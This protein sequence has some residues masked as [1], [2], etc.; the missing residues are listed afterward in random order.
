[1][2][3]SLE[4]PELPQV[5]GRRIATSNERFERSALVCLM[6]E[7]DEMFPDNAL[8]SVLCESVRLVRQY[9]DHAGARETKELIDELQRQLDE[10]IKENASL[11]LQITDLKSR[12]GTWND[13]QAQAEAVD[14]AT[15]Q[16]AAEREARE[17]AECRVREMSGN[18]DYGSQVLNE[19][20]RILHA[21]PEVFHLNETALEFTLRSLKVA[22]S[23][24]ALLNIGGCPN[25]D[26][27][28]THRCERKDVNHE[29]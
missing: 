20:L 22:H 28:G 6:H 7:Q 26:G 21:T 16:L 9:T 12:L 23:T 25:C 27:S 13:C 11:T 8:I 5:A 24:L 10:A 15:A 1:M 2:N 18:Y 3:E 4:Q 14:R 29:T 17:R 19:V